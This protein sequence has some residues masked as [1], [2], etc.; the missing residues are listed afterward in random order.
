M[1]NR[2]ALAAA[3]AAS[4]VWGATA[5]VAEE[6]KLEEMVVTAQKR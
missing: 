1:K 2:N 4:L 5:A 3:I 6:M